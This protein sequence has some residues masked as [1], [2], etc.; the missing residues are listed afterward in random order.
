M[1][2][3]RITETPCQCEEC[4]SRGLVGWPTPPDEPHHFL[5]TCGKHALARMGSGSCSKGGGL[6]FDSPRGIQP[7]IKRMRFPFET[8][9]SPQ[10]DFKPS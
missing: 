6:S 7:E 8:I 5:W 9:A 2:A 1:V 10:A 4:R 3:L